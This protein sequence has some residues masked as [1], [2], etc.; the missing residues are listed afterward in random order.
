MVL[1]YRMLSKK[2]LRVCPQIRAI[3][4]IMITCISQCSQIIAPSSYPALEKD[5]DSDTNPSQA[6][7]WYDCGKNKVALQKMAAAIATAAANVL[8][9]AYEAPS[10][11]AAP[12][13]GSAGELDAIDVAVAEATPVATVDALIPP[14]PGA[15]VIDFGPIVP[16]SLVE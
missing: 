2:L 9:N 14:L 12:A 4:L 13:K 7:T 6:I 3:M 1:C 10:L 5:H 8:V 15:I 11:D 16:T